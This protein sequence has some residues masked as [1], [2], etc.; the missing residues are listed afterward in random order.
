[1]LYAYL[2]RLAAWLEYAGCYCQIAAQFD[3]EGFLDSEYGVL[4]T[5]ITYDAQPLYNRI[6]AKNDGDN[7]NYDCFL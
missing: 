6:F 5:E 4:A 2:Y 3:E 7:T 1:M